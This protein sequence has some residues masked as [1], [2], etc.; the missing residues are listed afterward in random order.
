MARPEDI[1]EWAWAQV[2]YIRSQPFHWKGPDEVAAL[3]ARAIVE[4]A[5]DEREACAMLADTAT[6]T[7][8]MAWDAECHDP[9]EAQVPYRDEIAAAIRNRSVTDKE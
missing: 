7:T 2:A 4:S 1:P 5:E 6:Y 3:V 8:F 9:V